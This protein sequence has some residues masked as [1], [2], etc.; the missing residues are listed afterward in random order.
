MKEERFVAER[1]ARWKALAGLLSRAQTRGLASLSGDEARR[2]G[3][4]YRAATTDLAAARSFRL[5]EGTVSHVNRLCVAA[6]D[7]VYAGHR[8]GGGPRRAALFL[9]SEFPSLVRRTWP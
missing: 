1:S 9:A 4:L 3:A 5:S 2:L 6:H 7:L 8:G